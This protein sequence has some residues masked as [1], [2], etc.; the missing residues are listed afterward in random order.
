MHERKVAIRRVYVSCEVDDRLYRSVGR[1]N[2][3]IKRVHKHAGSD[4]PPTAGFLHLSSD[5]LRPPD[6]MALSR[7]QRE[8]G[9]SG[10]FFSRTVRDDGS[11]AAGLQAAS[12]RQKWEAGWRLP[13]SPSLADRVDTG[14]D[15]A[16]GGYMRQR[17]SRQQLNRV[18]PIRSRVAHG[19]S[20]GPATCTQT[21]DLPW[22]MANNIDAAAAYS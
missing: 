6:G 2:R 22:R 18:A 20:L 11:A 14:R 21:Q 12:P 7:M 13:S 19:V 17:R 9:S 16:V 1:P 3:L 4:E 5:T 10:A 8:S 15:A